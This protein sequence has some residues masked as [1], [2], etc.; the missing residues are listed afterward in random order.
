MG[1]GEA[2]R[3]CAA[4]GSEGDRERRIGRLGRA[5]RARQRTRSA[6]TAA[7]AAGLRHLADAVGRDRRIHRLSAAGALAPDRA[8]RRPGSGAGASLAAESAGHRIAAVG[9]GPNPRPRAQ[10]QRGCGRGGLLSQRRRGRPHSDH[11][12][13]GGRGAG[14]GR[15]H[16]GK[17]ARHRHGAAGR[18][19]RQPAGGHRRRAGSTLPSARV[20]SCC[21][22]RMWGFLSRSSWA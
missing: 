8:R 10:P 4:A 14:A 3:G 22:T 20:S 11:A 21:P 19:R 7:D 16:P 2:R 18:A 12:L 17:R 1:A 9:R 6:R 13:N 5:R 15:D